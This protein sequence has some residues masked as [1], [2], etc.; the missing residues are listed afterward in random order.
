MPIYEFECLDCRM[1]SSFLTPS[2][3][4][5]LEP[6][7]R[8]CGSARMSKLVSR[9]SVL[10]SGRSGDEGG[11]DWAGGE[12]SGPDD[13]GSGGLPDG[14]DDDGGGMGDDFE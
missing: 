5:P 3:K 6:K 10:R 14:G 9:V 7:C 8:A 1:R 4:T 2:A 11:E 12:E 13:Y